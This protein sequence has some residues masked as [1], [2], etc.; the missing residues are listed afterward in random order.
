MY[1]NRFV[2]AQPFAVNEIIFSA[3]G[4]VM[5]NENEGLAV[6]VECSSRGQKPAIVA[7]A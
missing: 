3:G 5:D 1:R 6:A 4:Q 2:I 7:G